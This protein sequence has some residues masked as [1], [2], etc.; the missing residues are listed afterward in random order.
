[1]SWLLPLNMP[2]SVWVGTDASFRWTAGKELFLT[3]R[4][5]AAAE[6]EYDTVTDWEYTVGGEFI[7]TRHF[8]LAGQ[9]SSEY[10]WGGGLRFRLYTPGFF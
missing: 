4:L 1:M 3:R 2:T 7:L 10:E 5:V 8:S 9:Y 6:V